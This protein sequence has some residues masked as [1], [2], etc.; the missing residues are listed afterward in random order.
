M[1]KLIYICMVL[2]LVFTTACDP[3]DDIHAEFDAMV[4]PIVGVAEYTLTDEDYDD[5]D[6]SFGN[7]SS[8]DDVKA[9]IPA[10]LA[11]KYPVWGKGSAVLLGYD[12][13]VGTAPGV[14]D[15]RFADDYSLANLDYPRG[16][17]NAVAF[18][19]D[20]DP[21]DYLGDILAAE[22]SNPSDGENVLVKFKQYVGEPIFGIADFYEEMFNGSLGTWENINVVG[23]RGWQSRSFGA[24][25]YAY[26]SGFSG[27]AQENEDWLISPMV[28]LSGQTNLT[29]QVRQVINFASDQT[30]LMQVLIS[31]DYTTG[32][33]HTDA[34]WDLIDFQNTPPGNNYTFVLSEEYDLAAY[35]GE[36]IH[37]ALKYESTTSVAAVWE[38]DQ[39]IIR[40]PGVEGETIRKET[41]YTYS[42]GEWEP[43]EGVYFMQDADFD[44]MGEESGQPGRFNNFGSSTPPDDYLPT[45]LG[46]KYP[47]AMEGDELLVIYD[48]FSSSSGAGI[49][50][51]LYSVV[52][53]EWAG[54][55]SVISTTLQFG[56]DGSKWVPDNTIKYTL[57][58]ADYDYIV[59]TFTAKY[60]SE[61]ANMD[62]FGNFNG[63]SWTTAMINE[64]LGAVLLHNF[65]GAAEGQKYNTT[66]S[67]YDGSTH[68]SS[69]TL[70]LEGGVY[71]PF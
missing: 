15:Y 30:D 16:G 14:N 26:M 19:P 31:T 3:M 20:E 32:G 68:D 65:P 22:I 23:D 17:D 45:F 37:I 35:E 64:A 48:Y 29:L 58:V 13:F 2:G 1:K 71:V 51:N 50:G 40:T 67:I 55:Q 62:N 54:Y 11:E 63:F 34:T 10:F 28:D 47:Y 8:V 43:S 25:E 4:D 44:S 38:V 12:L 42:G 6:L 46:I 56:H 41:F 27:G 9:M 49:R 39:V 18:F 33:D 7:F 61:T 66:Y 69:V 52:N 57:T 36:T 24:D 53:G 60:P 59:A 5:L 70:I 21:E